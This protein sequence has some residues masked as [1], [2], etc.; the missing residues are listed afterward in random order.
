MPKNFWKFKN[1]AESEVAELMLYGEISDVSW[2][3]DEVTPKQFHEDLITCEGKDLAVHIN[4]PGGDVFAAQAIYTQLKAYTG[5][6][7]MYIDGM[8]ASAATIIAC[9]G[10]TVIMPSNTI[11]MI[12]NPKSA[13]LGYFDAPQ[14]DKISESLGAVKQTI[15]NVYMARVQGALS[16]TQ[17]KHKMDS[18]SWMT[19]SEAKNYG[20]VDE[21]TDAI[22]IENKWEGDALIVNSVSCRLDR[23]KNISDLR[24][25]LPNE[26][27]KRSE[28]T[29]NENDFWQKLKNIVSGN[30]Q[31][32]TPTAANTQPQNNADAVQAAIAAERQRVAALDA[33]KNGNLAVD[34][35]IETAKANGATAESIKP[36]VDAIPQEQPT[37][38]TVN[39]EKML[40]AIKAILADNSASGAADV[41]PTPQGGQKNEAAEKAA[42]IEEVANYANKLMGVK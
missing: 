30:Q 6:V 41:L 39:E 9:A 7:T 10:D 24:A 1:E 21:I 37:V 28:S 11:Y 18:E 42:S 38:Q 23:F 13:M 20:F 14:L 5:K 40:T 16:E 34:S 26:K 29:M 35:I 31:T 33:M 36:Y 8:C 3:G 15:V 4:S 12:H 17:L 22:P 19:A 27:Q 25:I 32:P 2:Y